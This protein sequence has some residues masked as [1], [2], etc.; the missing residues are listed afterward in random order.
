MY[1]FA[2]NSM[3]VTSLTSRV[4]ML[5]INR[6]LIPHI[7]PLPSGGAIVKYRECHLIYR[8]IP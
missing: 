5:G 6:A 3:S 4:L 2:N 8:K 1:I 7:G